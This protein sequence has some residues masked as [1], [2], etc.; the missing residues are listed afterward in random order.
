MILIHVPAKGMT[1]SIP[2]HFYISHIS[3]YVPA[4]GTTIVLQHVLRSAV[5]QSTFPAKGTTANISNI[6]SQHSHIFVLLEYFLHNTTQES[7]QTS[8]LSPLFVHFFR[9][10]S[11]WIFMCASHSHYKIRVSSAAIPLS[12]PICSTFV[13]YLLP[14]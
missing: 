1:D 2:L 13:L 14:R 7:N 8:T 3:I 5:F 4:K 12:T 10:E 11:P 9:C 6:I